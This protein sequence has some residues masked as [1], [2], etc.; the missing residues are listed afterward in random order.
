[1]I[2]DGAITT[3]WRMQPG[4]AGFPLWVAYGWFEH[5]AA[6]LNRLEKDCVY[7]LK[8]VALPRATEAVVMRLDGLNGGAILLGVIRP[9]ADAAYQIS[10]VVKL[11]PV[12]TAPIAGAQVGG[13]YDGSEI[14]AFEVRFQQTR[15]NH[16]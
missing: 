11:G 14:W 2:L 12:L 3:N 8:F 10:D 5:S 6:N 1:M 7:R 16:V 13:D 9:R 4:P 15:M